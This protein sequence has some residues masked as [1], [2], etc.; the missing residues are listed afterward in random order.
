MSKQ[1]T[2]NFR[3]VLAKIQ[4]KENRITA[5][6][7][8]ALINAGSILLEEA[9]RRCPVDT[10]DLRD[11]GRIYVGMSGD[12]K[13]VSVT[14]KFDA[15]HARVA[16]E[17]WNRYKDAAKRRRN[18]PPYYVNGLSRVRPPFPPRKPR[19][20]EKFLE[21]AAAD[22]NTQRRMLTLLKRMLQQ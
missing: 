13:Q 16:H 3:H 7:P 12:G 22:K 21:R 18:L 20:G 6:I 11:S 14:I 1:K 2:V 8:Q 9:K 4:A 5:I 15:G 19:K 10:G 17:F